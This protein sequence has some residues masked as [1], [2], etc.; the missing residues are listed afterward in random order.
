VHRLLLRKIASGS[1]VHVDE[2]KGVLY[3][4]GHYMWIFA[5]MATVAYVYS[6]SRETSILDDVLAGFK[7]VLITN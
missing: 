3:G 4:G 6:A 7:G 2:T 5:D 1:L